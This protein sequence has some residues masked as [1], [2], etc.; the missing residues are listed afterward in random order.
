MRRLYACKYFVHVPLVGEKRCALMFFSE[1]F[2][3]YIPTL[4]K[5][6]LTYENFLGSDIYSLPPF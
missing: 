6:L 4:N 2:F 5:E 3:P 1:F